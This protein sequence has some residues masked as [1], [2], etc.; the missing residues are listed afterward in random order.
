MDHLMEGHLYQNVLKQLSLAANAMRLDPN[1]HERL[2][3]PKRALIVSVPVR[4]DDGSVKVFDGYRVQHSLTLGPGKG[5][6]RYH[7][8]VNLSEVAALACLMTFK[9]SLAGLPLGGAKGGIRVNA[10]SL[11]R[12]EKQKMTRRYTT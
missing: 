4:M 2:K 5:G 7:Q 10:S 11:S 8:D 3:K 9:C 12:T 1:I 6:I